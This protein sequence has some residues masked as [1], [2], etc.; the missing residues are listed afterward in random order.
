[1]FGLSQGQGGRAHRG[2][3]AVLV[4][5]A[6]ATKSTASPRRLAGRDA[7]PPG[8]RHA[9]GG[10]GPRPGRV[11]E[12]ADILGRR[13]DPL[14]SPRIR[15]R[16]D[17]PTVLQESRGRPL[18][19]YQRAPPSARHRAPAGRE[20]LGA[21][22]LA[23]SDL[24]SALKRAFRTARWTTP[25]TLSCKPPRSRCA[26][27]RCPIGRHPSGDGRFAVVAGGRP[28]VTHYDTLGGVPGGQPRR[29]HPGDWPHPPDQGAHDSD[30]APLRG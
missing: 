25:T 12:D 22:V 10:A 18:A 21:D 1:M 14:A 3:P 29:G 24:Y 11:Y 19:G 26:G 23:K 5:G 13:Q 15:P 30:R 2:P 9:A 4:G 17:R 7:A 16:L 27:R 8:A 6:A 28:S 20:H